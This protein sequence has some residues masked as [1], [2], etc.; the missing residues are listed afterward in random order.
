MRV[1][2][3]FMIAAASKS[4]AGPRIPRWAFAACLSVTVVVPRPV[5]AQAAPELAMR[6]FATGQVKKGVRSI[7][8]GG[9]GATWGNYGLVWRDASTALLDGGAT[10]YTNGNVFS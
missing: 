3:E 8:F 5:L 2:G 7:G 10:L 1:R 9:D 6:D 4:G